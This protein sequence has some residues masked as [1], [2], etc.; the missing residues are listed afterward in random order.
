LGYNVIRGLM[1]EASR[2]HGRVPQ[3]VSFKGALQTLQANETAL[4]EG[5]PAVRAWLWDIRLESIANDEVGRRPNRVEPRA[6]QRRPK[7]YPLL[8]VPRAEA[9]EALLKTG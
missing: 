1:V 3:H 2:A 4:R 9:K 8:M 7:P 5:M 6:R